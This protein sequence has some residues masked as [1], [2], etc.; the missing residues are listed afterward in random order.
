MTPAEVQATQCR[1]HYLRG[2]ALLQ[3]GQFAAA[4]EEFSHVLSLKPQNAKV[5]VVCVF[6]RVCARFHDNPRRAG[7]LPSCGGAAENAQRQ[8]NAGPQ[9]CLAHPAKL[10]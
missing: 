9:P 4:A 7:L 2:Q 5:H 8:G 1:L 10:L 3:A 6:M